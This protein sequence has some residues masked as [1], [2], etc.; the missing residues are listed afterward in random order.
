M[1]E[2]ELR[3]LNTRSFHL[4]FIASPPQE[5]IIIRFHK[6]NV[7]TRTISNYLSILPLLI[8]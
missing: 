3:A 7:F 1:D 8:F 6:N 4:P 5:E 2:S